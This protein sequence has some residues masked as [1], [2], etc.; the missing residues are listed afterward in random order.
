MEVHQK[1]HLAHSALYLCKFPCSAMPFWEGIFNGIHEN[2][3]NI[4]ARE[5]DQWVRVRTLAENSSVRPYETKQRPGKSIRQW[6]S[7]REDTFPARRWPEILKSI[8]PHGRKENIC[9]F[10][11][12]RIPSV[13]R[14]LTY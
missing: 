4:R 1:V 12:S 8:P 7:I 14:T 10:P 3:M 5:F 6:K 9:T 2:I 11:A 13:R